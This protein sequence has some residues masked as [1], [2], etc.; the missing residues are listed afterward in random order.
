M[1]RTL[2]VVESK[3][4]SAPASAWEPDPRECYGSREDAEK[5]RR[6]L[7]PRTREGVYRVV[8][9]GRRDQG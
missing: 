7:G 1:T 6:R 4:L 5:A 2:Y 9:Y 3:L 8:E